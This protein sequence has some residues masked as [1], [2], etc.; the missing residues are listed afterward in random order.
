[1]TIKVTN[2]KSNIIEVCISKWGDD[3]DTSY[4]SIKPNSTETWNRSA[5][6]PF[7]MLIKQGNKLSTYCVSSKSNIVVANSDEVKDLYTNTYLTPILFPNSV[8]FTPESLQ[9]YKEQFPL[10]EDIQK[11]S[12][13]E[14]VKLNDGNEVDWN[15]LKTQNLQN[16]SIMNTQDL[17]ISECH[18]SIGYVVMDAICI[19]IGGIG[20]RS[21]FNR[22]TAQAV[23]IAAG[24]A[25]TPIG[26][27]VNEIARD[28]TSLA[29]RA[30][31]ILSILST[32]YSTSC[33]GAVIKAFLASLK[34][35]QMIIYGAT[36]MATILAAVATDGVAFVAEVVLVLGS[37]TWFVLDLVNCINVCSKSGESCELA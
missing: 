10:D 34:W 23:A 3:G 32:L 29:Q 6:K 36:A 8:K 16:Q 33:L 13:E 21:S 26:R 30:R 1:M 15:F 14:L 12:Y 28:G 20:L 5:D 19:A 2:N 17:T 9:L 35:Y 4:F 27:I 22:A 24:P 25:I 31:G 7:I 37:C 11:I 18:L